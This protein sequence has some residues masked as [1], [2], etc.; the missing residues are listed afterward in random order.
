MGN[1]MASAVG[2]LRAA[3]VSPKDA[4][5]VTIYACVPLSRLLVNKYIHYSSG[6]NIK[7]VRSKGIQKCII[8]ELYS[9]EFANFDLGRPVV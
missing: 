9:F 4:F 6:A 8:S 3:T 2:C 1:V 5:I 7:S